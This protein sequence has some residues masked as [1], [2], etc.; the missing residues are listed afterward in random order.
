MKFHRRSFLAGGLAAGF[1]GLS[2]AYAFPGKEKVGSGKPDV[3]RS[4]QGGLASGPEDR[5]DEIAGDHRIHQIAEE[6]P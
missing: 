3:R 5:H 6:G 4:G 1:A 2:P